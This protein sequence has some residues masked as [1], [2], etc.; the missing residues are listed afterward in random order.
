MELHAQYTF[1]AEGCR[2]HLGKQLMERFKLREGSDPQVYGIG[3][4]ELWEIE[5]ERHQPGLVV[6]T[7]GWPLAT[8]PTA[9]RSCTT[10][11]T[12]RSRSAS[13]SA[14]ATATHI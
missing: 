6:H 11:R 14:W 1:F 12:T 3:I 9:A 10:W 4:K 8:T 7:A 13:S 2:G 5:P